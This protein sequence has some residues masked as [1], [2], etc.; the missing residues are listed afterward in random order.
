MGLTQPN[1]H[2][3]AAT[4]VIYMRRVERAVAAIT[5]VPVVTGSISC[6][7]TVATFSAEELAV[8]PLHS[9]EEQRSAT[10]FTAGGVARCFQ[11]GAAKTVTTTRAC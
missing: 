4:S 6:S 5:T 1:I 3:P 11:K 7:T 2:G 9:L 10:T 8:H